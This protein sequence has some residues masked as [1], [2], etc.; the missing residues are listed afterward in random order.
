MRAHAATFRTHHWKSAAEY[1]HMTLNNLVLLS[2]WALMSWLMGPALFFTMYL[3]STS[4]AGAG[5]I[6]LFT[7]QHNFEHAYASGDQDW[8]YDAAA[9]HG[10]SFLVLPAWLNWFTANIGY[11]HVH[12]LSSR[13][14]NYCLAAC[15]KDNEALFADVRRL[16]LADIGAS[17]KFILWDTQARR[18]ISVAEH[19]VSRLTGT[20]LPP[21]RESMGPSEGDLK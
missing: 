18:I 9:L 14:P 4:L 12:H 11:H 16:G 5:G 6:V 21:S 1:R 2:T 13:I 7:V 20:R 15:H 10:T 17:L 3:L 19:Q 8:D